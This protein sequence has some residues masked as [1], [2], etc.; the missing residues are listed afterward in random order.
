MTE[1][2]RESPVRLN[3][4][5]F[6]EHSLG[7]LGGLPAAAL[8]ASCASLVTRT[9]TPVNGTLRL[10]LAH[11]PEL[12]EPAG[13][14]RVVPEGAAE[15]VYV[16]RLA[17]GQFAALSPICTH[18]GCT[19]EIADARLVCPCHGSTYARDGRVVQGPAERPLARYRTELESDD[20]LVIH[21][22][23]RT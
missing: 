17:D 13:S 5:G 6:L 2:N 19:V 18:L 23:S 4:R 12:G 3:R 20:V 11:Y 16:L 8:L 14:L 1:P 22:A 15:P 10:P 21:L 9:V 7:A